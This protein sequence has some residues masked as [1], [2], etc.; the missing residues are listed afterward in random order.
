MRRL[1]HEEAESKV[2]IELHAMRARHKKMSKT[3]AIYERVR[4]SVLVESPNA[5]HS[6]WSILPIDSRHQMMF[7]GMDTHERVRSSSGS[8]HVSV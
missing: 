6:I 1:W 7:K 3:M 8:K 4:T 5:C 2:C